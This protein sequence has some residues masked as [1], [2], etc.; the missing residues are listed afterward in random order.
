[1]KLNKKPKKV[2]KK[3]KTRKALESWC[4]CTKLIYDS[5]GNSSYGNA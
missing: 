3:S 1:M 4:S 2:K 5:K